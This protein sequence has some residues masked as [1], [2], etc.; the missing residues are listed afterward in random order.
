[1]RAYSTLPNRFGGT[2]F[3]VTGTQRNGG[4]IVVTSE[5]VRANCP[6]VRIDW[7]LINRA[8][9]FKITDVSVDGVSTMAA[10]RDAFTSLVQK[11]GGRADVVLAVLRQEL[12][13]AR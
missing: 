13:A 7:H 6:P 11:N 5:A 2:P 10:Q 8:G 9:R 3:R 1:V 12:A 4:G